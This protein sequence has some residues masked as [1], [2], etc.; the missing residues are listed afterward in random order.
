M[1]WLALNAKTE[2]FWL[3]HHFFHKNNCLNIR[4]NQ[5]PNEKIKKICIHV[6][7]SNMRG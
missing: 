3:K 5:G 2:H 6:T 7:F 1:V 4:S